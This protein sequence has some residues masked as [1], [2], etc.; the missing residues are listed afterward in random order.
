MAT[1]TN[2]I[3]EKKKISECLKKA[4]K[5]LKK[6]KKKSQNSGLART[7]K[8][9]SIDKEIGDFFLICSNMQY[10]IERFT[11]TR[12]NIVKTRK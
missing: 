3:F 2:T 11:E 6:E 12:S 4:C 1:K 10:V 9:S 5:Q 7:R 8:I